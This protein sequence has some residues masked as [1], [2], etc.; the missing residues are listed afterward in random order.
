[1]NFQA[2]STVRV[3][4]TRIPSSA[5][6]FHEY[7]PVQY[8]E[9]SLQIDAMDM[10]KTFAE[11]LHLSRLPAPEPTVF[12]GDPLKFPAWKASFAAL[13]DA[14]NIAPIERIHYLRKYLSGEAK[15]VV[16]GTF[17]FDTEDAYEKAKEILEDRYG[18]AFMVSEAFRDKLHEWPKIPPKDGPAL[19]KF[20]DF[21]RQCLIAMSHVHELDILNDCR[22]NRKLLEKLPDWLVQRWSRIVA[23]SKRY[24]LFETF[25]KFLTKEADIACNPITSLS[26]TVKDSS[27]RFKKRPT[28][29]TLASNTS[30]SERNEAKKP[31]RNESNR[32]CHMCQ[33]KNHSLESCGH[34][35]RKTPIERR[36]F[37]LKNGLCFGCLSRGHL[38][39]DCHQKSICEICEKK[40]PSCMHGDY[41]ALHPQTQS[42]G[43][44]KPSRSEDKRES[45]ST[46][47]QAISRRTRTEDDGSKTSMIV[48]VWL[49]SKCSPS[50]EELVYALLDS[51]SDTTFV[52]EDTGN[53]ISN[54]YESTKLKI[55]TMTSTSVVN[56]ERYSDLQVRGLNSPT[57]ISLPVTYSRQFIPAHRSHIPTKETARRWPHLKQLETELPTMQDCDVGLLI[58]YNCP[59]ALAPK[60]FIRGNENEPFAQQ[61]DLGWSIVGHTSSTEVNEE[62]SIS[63]RIVAMN[64]PDELIFKDSPDVVR[65]VFRAQ[66]KEEASAIIPLLEA[67]FPERKYEDKTMSQ[68][69]IQ[70]LNIMKTEVHQNDEGFYEMPLPFKNGKP[71]LPNNKNAA[72]RRLH[73]LKRRFKDEKYFN[74]YKDFLE[75][76]IQLGD[77]EEV[78]ECTEPSQAW[79]VPH[80]GVYHPKKPNKI[81]VVFDC[82]AKHNGLSLNDHLLQGPDLMNSLVG[83]LVRF[84][85]APIAFMGDVER[86]FHQFRVNPEDRDY[87]RFLWWKDADLSTDPVAYRM[88]VHLFGAVSSPGCANFGLKKLASDNMELFSPEV[89]NFLANDFYV[90]DGLRS[91][92][93]VA[94]AIKLIQ[95]ARTLCSKGNLR[96]HK[97]VSNSP[98]V[99]QSIPE[100]ERATDIKT[101]DMNF[102]DSP[103]ERALGIQWCIE[104]DLLQFKL[105]VNEKPM[106]RRGILSTVAS[107]YDPLGCL[108]PFVLLGKQLLQQM[109]KESRSWDEP[110]SEELRPKWEQWLSNIPMLAHIRIRRCFIPENFGKVT[111]R[112]MHHFSDASFQ[113]YGQCSYLRQINEKN[114]VHCSLIIG[115]ARVTPLRAITMPRLELT[116]AVVSAKISDM[117]RAE[118]KPVD[119]EYFWTDSKVVL[120]YINNNSR[121]FHV[122]VANRIQRI[123]DSSKPKQWHYVNTAD[124]PAD[125]A[126]RGML[127]EELHK[128]N[129]YIGPTFLW[130]NT[131]PE[132]NPVELETPTDDPEV[133]KV[134]VN[135][136][137]AIPCESENPIL[138]RLERFSS[139]NS[140]IRAI[141][142]LKRLATGG[143]SRKTSVEDMQQ[144]KMF[145]LKLLQNKFYSKEIK[146]L[147]DQEK[148]LQQ[149]SSLYKL[150]PFLDV[151]GILRVGGRL[152]RSSLHDD[153]KHPII[154]PKEGHILQL[155]IRH[156]H[157]RIAHQGRGLT[158]GQIRAS[159]YWIVSCSKVVS[160]YLY[161]CVTCRKERGNLQTQKMADLPEVRLEPSP[162]FTHCGIDCFGPFIIK[163]GRKELKR[164]GLLI[165]C[166]ASR[167]VHVET[168]DDMSTDAF[169]NGL[170]CVMALRGSIRSIRCDQGSNFVGAINELNKAT[171][172][173]EHKIRE[174]LTTQRCDF[175][176]NSPHSSHMG[177]VWERHIRTIRSVLTSMLNQHSLRLDTSTL[178]TFLYEAMAIVNSRPLSVENLHDPSGPEPLTPNH[179]LTL[180]SQVLLPP[181]GDFVEEDVYARKR[182]RK[183]QY[184]ANEFWSRWR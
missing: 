39:K 167:A 150:H 5:V 54:N 178:R 61:T 148:T 174:Y 84:R 17:F 135:T 177:G 126:S 44:R 176:L 156:H 85:E 152:V 30:S 77:A 142:V 137:N 159:G 145:I 49:S 87:L 124:N 105:V 184:L 69:D 160:S 29:N 59:Q 2:Q 9:R 179:L 98:E 74:D 91:C 46:A 100:S 94:E 43:I 78:H 41:E 125:H 140:A 173:M 134:I 95:E 27:S 172:E 33:M 15:E 40:H 36:D 80:H 180:K 96:L 65:Y 116:A 133:K 103:V 19:R 81:R 170:R 153:V 55:S 28:A 47:D 117:L 35:K 23:D 128:S 26:Q 164:Y 72:N 171:G 62:T 86:M 121:R 3:P 181:P 151:N 10:M 14:R 71:N 22:E 90:D 144:A 131:L 163:E 13:I 99:M 169:I 18:N 24:P 93:T 154:L 111:R 82:S 11:S 21:L 110:L 168:L 183:V 162:P 112:E 64:I 53:K 60:N 48:P 73:Q 70:F 106:T 122:F 115:K 83:V 101:L 136:T 57:R 51:Q 67:D 68:E 155:I 123:H 12:S 76:I 50:K 25:V 16:E 107:V 6:P 45:S 20:S 89:C 166:M 42:G 182:W 63:H 58:G 56:C 37:L 141:A 31:E 92:K 32:H 52:L 88:K 113:G 34:F 109:C 118:M 146:I 157:E 97:F 143:R 119:D 161:H 7:N 147:R 104:N 130:K 8:T 75:K 132:P 127:A 175:L 165:T 38:S 129:W 120:G 4:E 158:V 149:S 138:R 114:E 139:W 108:A 79:Y 66:T 1:M 102:D